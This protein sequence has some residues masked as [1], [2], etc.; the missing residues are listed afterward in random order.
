MAISCFPLLE[1]YIPS[2]FP[3][4]AND[5]RVDFRS[6]PAWIIRVLHSKRMV[7]IAIGMYLHPLAGNQGQQ[8]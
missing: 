4:R 3:M 2:S 1:T 5:H 6:D 8:Q 7:S